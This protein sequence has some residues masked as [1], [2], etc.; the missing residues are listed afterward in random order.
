MTSVET[1]TD[2]FFDIYIAAN[3]QNPEG[4]QRYIPNS[5]AFAFQSIHVVL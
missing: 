4:K 3:T 1:A 5:L 2:N